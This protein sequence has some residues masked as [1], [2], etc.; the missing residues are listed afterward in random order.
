VGERPDEDRAE[1]HGE[2]D[3][4]ARDKPK[5]ALPHE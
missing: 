3:E 2:R 1:E 5:A 4:P